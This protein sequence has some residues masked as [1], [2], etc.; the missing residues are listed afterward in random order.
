MRRRLLLGLLVALLVV[1]G[2]LAG[3]VASKLHLVHG[4]REALPAPTPAQQAI[5]TRLLADV[6]HLATTIGERRTPA[7]LAAAEQWI[8]GELRAAGF[9][10][11]RQAFTDAQGREVGNLEVVVPGREPAL[12]QIVV[13]AHYDTVAGSPGADDNASGVAANLHLARTL[14]TAAPRRTVRFVFFT[15]EEAPFGL[16]PSMGSY[17]YAHD[18]AARGITVD[19]MIA[20]D[21]LGFYSDVEG[22]QR[23]PFPLNLLFPSKA[24]FLGFVTNRS[25]IELLDR[26]TAAFAG[27]TPLPYEGV[28]VDIRDISRSDHWSFWQTG[29]PALL[30][31]DTANF[32]NPNYHH[33]T[34]TPQTLDPVRFAF[35]VEGLAG[36]VRALADVPERG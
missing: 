21:L 8:E 9:E 6:T 25:S 13:G 26:V 19:A 18:L 23:Y 22:S 31:T 33:P 16:T 14:R 24:N 17:S 2:G 4:A 12:P 3:F 34:D 35:A 29:V 1:G 32:R 15:N 20:F 27:A 10:V 5:A 11:R 36:V 7:Q 28:A 30:V